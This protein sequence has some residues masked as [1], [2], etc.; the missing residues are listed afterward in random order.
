MITYSKEAQESYIASIERL[1]KE[2]SSV[3]TNVI[4]YSDLHWLIH[5]AL[6]DLKNVVEKEHKAE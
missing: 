3:P 1:Q 4:N 6:N 5:S 2:L